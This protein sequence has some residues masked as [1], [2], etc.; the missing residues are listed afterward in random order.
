[1]QI[2]II[3]GGFKMYSG[4]KTVTIPHNQDL[5]EGSFS[6]GFL[7]KCKWIVSIKQI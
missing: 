2:D 3:I 4:M 6:I 7:I 1:M 5:K